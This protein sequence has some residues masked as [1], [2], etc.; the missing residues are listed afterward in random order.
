MK[1]NILSDYIYLERACYRRLKEHSETS[2]LEP[3]KHEN[4]PVVLEL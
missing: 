3:G 2:T 4:R 1:N